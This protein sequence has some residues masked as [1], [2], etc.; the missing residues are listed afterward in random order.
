MTTSFRE[1]YEPLLRLLGDLLE[2]EE[3]EEKLQVEHAH[4]FLLPEGV[5]PYESVY[6]ST[7]KLLHQKPWQEVKQFYISHGFKL[8]NNELHPEDHIAVEF[9]FM[10]GLIE[11]QVPIEEQ[12]RFMAEHLMQ[13]VPDLL[14]DIIN[15]PYAVVYG[16]IAAYGKQFIKQELNW[17]DSIQQ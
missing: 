13:W 11:N 14:E 3:T 7:E 6:R 1:I 2:N 12:S 9:A 10:S 17:L 5:K 8:E 16:E 15:N 4:L